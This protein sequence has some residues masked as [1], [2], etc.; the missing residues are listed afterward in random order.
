[1][2]GR[3]RKMSLWLA[4]LTILAL[5][6]QYKIQVK[7]TDVVHVEM[8]SGYSG[9]FT[10]LADAFAAA[11]AQATADDDPAVITLMDNIN[12]V[13]SGTPIPPLTIEAGSYITLD[14]NGFCYN[15]EKTIIADD[16][17]LFVNHGSFTITDTNP[18]PANFYLYDSGTDSWSPSTSTDPNA[19]QISGGCISGGHT[20]GNGGVI[21]SDGTLIL[22]TGTMLGNK[23]KSGG[24]VYSEDGTIEFDQFYL[25]GNRAD[26][27]GG[28]YLKNSTMEMNSGVIGDS[29]SVTPALESVYGNKADLNGGGIYVDIDSSLSILTSVVPPVFKYNT[30]K[31][32]GG[33][34]YLESGNLTMEGG[35]IQKNYAKEEG[36]GIYVKATTHDQ[37]IQVKGTIKIL[38]NVKDGPDSTKVKSNLFLEQDGTHV[39]ALKPTGTGLSNISEIYASTSIAPTSTQGVLVML[40]GNPGTDYTNRIKSDEEYLTGKNAVDSKYYFVKKPVVT[41]TTT[42]ATTTSETTTTTTTTTETTTSEATTTTATTSTS[43]AET[44]TTVPTTT[45]VPTTAETTTAEATSGEQA[46]DPPVTGNLNLTPLWG[47]LILVSGVVVIMMKKHKE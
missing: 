39:N 23:A 19:V 20:S 8:D 38:D 10:T 29:I 31:K 22:D 35:I 32:K 30:A 9:D 25:N 43:T 14:L 33:A 6:S 16:G 28:I 15:V 18:L 36:G 34:V 21:Y 13:E 7:A 37:Q 26:N 17:Q 27:G 5:T 44:S 2:K 4:L 41:P 40:A 45:E 46:G 47:L 42:T 12:L 11:N 24:A 3:Q 1:M